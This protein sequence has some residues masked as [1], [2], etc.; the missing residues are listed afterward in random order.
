[1][2]ISR[3]KMTKT[4]ATLLAL[5]MVLMALAPVSLSV[6]LT[7]EIEVRESESM[8]D[9]Q[10]VALPAG[11]PLPAIM[12]RGATIQLGAQDLSTGEILQDVIFTSNNPTLASV[13]ADG[14]LTARA[15]S[16]I[17]VITARSGGQVIAGATLRLSA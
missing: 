11:T 16:G 2:N 14:L 3:K 8:T 7:N 10:L 17:V 12:R 6:S 1:M 15:A 5:V 4:L 13:D 9:I